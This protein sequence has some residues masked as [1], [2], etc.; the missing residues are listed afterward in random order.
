MSTDHPTLISDR[1]VELEGGTPHLIGGRCKDCGAISY[2][3]AD[4]CTKCLSDGVE[5]MRLSSHGTLYSYSVVHQAPKG[6]NV[7]YALGYVDLPEG[8]RVLAHLDAKKSELVIDGRMTLSHGVVGS[9]A[10]GTPLSTY[11]FVPA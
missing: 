9:A 5:A 2:P 4:V 10:D 8:V 3:R 7:P 6:W 11:T 1:L